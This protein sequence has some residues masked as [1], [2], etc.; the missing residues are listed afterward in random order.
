MGGFEIFPHH[1]P[2]E[3]GAVDGN[4]ESL[5]QNVQTPCVIAMF[6]RQQNAGEAGGITPDTFQSGLNLPSTEPGIHQ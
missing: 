3:R 2:C 1:L 4:G 6:M 5:R